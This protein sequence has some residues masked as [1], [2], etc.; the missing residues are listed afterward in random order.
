MPVLYSSPS[1][2][3]PEGFVQPAQH[4]PTESDSSYPSLS[5]PAQPVVDDSEDVRTSSRSKSIKI[6]EEDT[7]LGEEAGDLPSQSIFLSSH[8]P[9]R[10]LICDRPQL[11]SPEASFS[12]LINKT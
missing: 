1:D 6:V 8:S 10:R 11:V 7:L 3:A 9:R 5:L 12:S 4:V 2:V